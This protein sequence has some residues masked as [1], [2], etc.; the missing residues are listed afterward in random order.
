MLFRS[1]SAL[2]AQ[3]TVGEGAVAF[4]GSGVGYTFFNHELPALL[5]NIG[6]GALEGL[7]IIF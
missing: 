5:T 7:E 4:V 6:E 3:G 1:E 2:Y